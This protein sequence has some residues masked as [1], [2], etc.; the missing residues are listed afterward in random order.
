MSMIMKKAAKTWIGVICLWLGAGMASAAEPDMADYTAYP[1]FMAQSVKPNILV[2]L[3]NSGSMNFNAYGSYPGDGGTVTDAPYAGA[4]HTATIDVQVSSADDDAEE[5]AAG[6]TYN[7][8]DL[9]LGNVTVPTVGVRFQ[10]LTI[11]QGATI[12]SAYITFEASV[13]H[14]EATRVTFTG[15]AIDDAP[16]FDI[17]STDSDISSRTDTTARVK[18]T[19]PPW[20]ANTTY[21][22]PD[23]SAI[24]QEIVDRSGWTSGNAM[25]FKITGTGIREARAYED[26]PSHS[27][28]LH[29]VYT[30]VRYYG[31]FD[32]DAMYTYNASNTRF[33]RDS[34]GDWSGNWLNWLCMRRIDVARKILVGGAATVRDGSGSTTLVAD[35]HS[36]QPSRY[37][38]R[39]FDDS[40]APH[41]SPY[42]GT[43]NYAPAY[44][45]LYVYDSSWNY[46]SR[47]EVRVA[48]NDTDEPDDF[49]D[50]NVVGILQRV[51]DRARFG[52][53]FYNSSEGG[54][55]V[56]YVDSNNMSAVVSDIETRKGDT[57]TPLAEAF[58]EGVRYFRQEAP[59][60]YS[61]DYTVSNTWDPYYWNDTGEFVECGKSFVLL[62]TDGESTQDLNIPS[63]LQD[64]DND[65]NDPGTFLWNGSDYLDDVAL[66][67]HTNDMRS[68][69]GTQ[70]ISLYTVF[71]FGQGSS[72]LKDA[73]KNGGFTDKNDNDVP[74]LQ[75]EWDED[76]DGVP[77]NYFEAE[78]GYIL[79]QRILEAITD[80]LK[81]AAAGTAVSVLATTG[82]GEGNVVQAYFRPSITSG[83][84][85]IR[86]VGYLQSLW[87]DTYGN[88]REDTDGDL[89]LDEETDKVISYFVDSTTGDTRIKRYDV[90]GTTP[91]PSEDDPYET[92][93]MDE[94][95]PLWEAGSLLAERDPDD[96]KIFTFLD[97][98][99]DETVDE[100]TDNPLDHEGEV[101]SFDLTSA[102]DIKP[103]L[104][105]KDTTT[106]GYLGSTHDTRVTNLINYIRG[107]DVSGLRKRTIDGEVWKLGDIVHSTPVSVSKPPD[108]YHIIYSDESYQ[109]YYD[110]FK[111]RETV[112][113]VGSNDGMLHAFTSWQY[114][115]S[116]VS[117]YFARPSEA[118]DTEDIGEE[119]WA[120]IPQ[121]LLPHLKWLPSEDYTHVYYVD[122]KPKV[123]DAKILDDDTH[124]TDA[125]SDDNWGTILLAGLRMGGKHISVS[126]D[127]DDGSGTTVSETR[128]FYSSYSCLDVTDP[129]NPRLLWERSYD[130]LELTTTFPAV[131]KVKEKW[132]AVFG[133]GPSDYDGTSNNSGH[134][135]VVDLKTG[136]PYKNGSNDWLFESGVSEAFMSAPVSIDK[137][138]N[139]NVDA[140]YLGET[141]FDSG[142]STWK[143]RLYKIAIPWVD[144]GTYDGIDPDNYVDD[145][146]DSSDP[147]VFAPLFNA[148]RPITSPIA[149]SIDTFDNVWLYV[150]SGRYLSEADKTNTD[151]Q[152]LF[153]VKDPFFN[154]DHTPTGLYGDDYYHKYDVSLELTHSDLFD[155]DDYVIIEGG[156]VYLTDGTTFG[157]FDQ[158]LSDAREKD[159]WRRTLTLS[160]ERV[161]TKFAVLGGIVF[162]PSFVPNADICGYGGDSYLYGQYYETGTAYYKPVFTQGTET[163]TIQGQSMERVKE[164]ISLGAGKASAVGVHVGAEEG[165]KGFIQQSTGTI[166]K[167]SLNPAFNIKSG[168]RSWRER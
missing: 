131:I 25:V 120:Y 39:N 93:E 11:P 26:S 60:Y 111:D 82:E 49:L 133:S 87:V 141:S 22:T 5:T 29:V 143:G 21:Q 134:V 90:S 33:E 73:A 168:L 64:Y 91:Y 58:Y 80:I 156:D 129:R 32:P 85:E 154:E 2:I 55:V 79:E 101:V 135:F 152:Y 116:G 119:L 43:Y 98:D 37:W 36:N 149:L 137:N 59:Y 34:S 96:R 92:V 163:V 48:K 153:G 99:K 47:Y 63:S 164:K 106:W 128:H 17:G 35:D 3:D 12:S 71:A 42:H 62:I 77:D 162:T 114:T 127:F 40:A 65:G 6:Y 125:D 52:L 146:T 161:I 126:D 94:I 95:H 157:D 8:T 115:D 130:D 54:R 50:G 86:W 122:L 105:V 57:W 67:A 103:Y 53:E 150:G 140:V 118:S 144:G 28:K 78:S 69:D 83:L 7:H 107:E 15:Q 75:A 10:N 76:G 56:Q 41:V 81:R 151:T 4:G 113:Y 61:S 104:G 19:V 97:K 13:D 147:W 124:Y 38:W 159:G 24:V 109:A 108:N 23:L 148:E 45:R 27:P 46:V 167:E 136:E 74:D 70:T 132:F 121:S 89:S 100:T 145:P 165:A 51:G 66:W 1:I 158:L 18:W 110:A 123:F 166:V 139:Y 84:D 9:D 155:A 112:I 117:R 102:D 160:G 72:S 30:G 138:L 44:G 20:T 88:L 16:T 14:S 68:L 142:T 31:Y